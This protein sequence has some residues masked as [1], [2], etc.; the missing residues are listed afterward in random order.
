MSGKRISLRGRSEAGIIAFY[1]GIAAAA[2]VA[3]LADGVIRIIALSVLGVFALYF[4]FGDVLLAVSDE[5]A[6]KRNP[7]DNRIS[8]VGRKVSVIEDFVGGPA[9]SRGKVRLAG[10]TWEARSRD[11]KLHRQGDALVVT[12]VQGLV[13]E[14]EDRPA[15]EQGAS[16]G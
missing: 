1:L 9:G 11:G 13:L 10:E 2:A 15:G 7:H 14:V 6:T 16:R 12:D 8:D 4:L 5:R 3:L